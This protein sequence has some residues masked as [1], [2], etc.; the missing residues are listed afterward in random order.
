MTSTAH[1]AAPTNTGSDADRREAGAQQRNAEVRVDIQVLRGIAVLAV[2]LHHSGLTRMS[3]G[4]LG[5]D[6]FF[7]ISGYLI[8]K[9]IA[10]DIDGGRFSFRGFYTR[11]ARRLLPAAYCTL[12]VTTLLAAMTLTQDR[13]S[14]FVAQLVGAATFTANFVL[15]AQT[16][17]FET[18]AEFKPLL[19][20]WSLSVEEQYYLLAPLLLV[21][22]RPRWRLPTL[23][24]L[25]LASFIVC[26][27]M[28]G[29]GFTHWRLPDLDSRQLAFYML[30]TRAWEM[31]AGS[32]LACA[33][34]RGNLPRPSA[35]V[36]WM[37]LLVLCS[38]CAKHWDPLH[39]RADALVAVLLTVLL[40]AGDSRWIGGSLA[41]RAMARV[42]DLSYSLYLVHWPLFALAAS[43]YLGGIPVEAR[44]ALVVL[45]MLLA[46]LQYEYVEKRFR[47]HGR[48]PARGFARFFV[49][50][51]AVAALPLAV[52]AFR[53]ETAGAGYAYLR[54]PNY[55]LSLACATGAALSNP[56]ACSTSA[57]PAVAVWGDSFA[58]HLIP[59]LLDV[60]AIGGSM[61]QITK[62]ACA[63]I[64]GVASIDANYDESWAAGCL[65][66]A[67][68]ALELITRNP[69]IR[70]VILSSP[71]SGYLDDGQ[72]L[73]Y[74]DGQT[75]HRD[76]TVALEK[77]VTTVL[78]LQ[79]HG[80]QVL[81]VAPPPKAGFDIGACHEQSGSRLLVLGRSGCDF[82]PAESRG[83]QR[84][85]F[86]ALEE[87]VARTG[88]SLVRF[89]TLL[90]SETL[91]RTSLPNGASA[92]KDEGHLTVVG[93]R[94]L[95]PRLGLDIWIG[96]AKHP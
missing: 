61:M 52:G 53:P 39:P 94:E 14:D 96:H 46:W 49:G 7:V 12:V 81:L 42:G 32:L 45:S 43:A 34:L 58:M 16:G 25:A 33:S 23:L 79:R 74:T 1:L 55:G 90:C 13:W 48:A 92:Y 28:V 87:V 68:R 89:D 4:Y 19:H 44:A 78:E 8:T 38:L 10:S 15:P 17:Y 47:H 64:P 69:S 36:K 57:H 26:A 20:T 3:G 21:L 91:C 51:V 60:P 71:Y 5:V 37:G 88:A 80:K 93:S 66:F 24:I 41:V 30:P 9:N 83:L 65:L 72:L 35:G 11:R 56:A 40:I 73:V 54:E 82:A 85:V 59:G 70:H 22:L 63:P 31:L 50:A 76:R 77:L 27:V 18:A 29:T 84:G 86:A 2:L 75:Q 6:I 62:A 67:Q 95:V